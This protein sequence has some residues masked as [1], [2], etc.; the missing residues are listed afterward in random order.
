[1]KS[2]ATPLAGAVLALVVGV[3]FWPVVGGAR[4]FFHWDLRYE[5]VPLWHVSQEAL[6][7]GHWPFWIDG[8]YCGHPALLRQEVALFYPLTPLLLV[9]NAPDHRLADLYTLFHLW[10][11]GFAAYLLLRDL[12]ADFVSGLF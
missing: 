11:A 1:M 3:A 2:A 5:I 4:S 12:E 7:S 6:R 10:L 8:E 9:T